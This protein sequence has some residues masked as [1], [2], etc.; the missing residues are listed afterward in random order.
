MEIGAI[1]FFVKDMEKMVTSWSKSS[2]PDVQVQYRLLNALSERG[3]AVSK[4]V[5]W[6]INP[7]GNKVLLTRFYGSPIHKV[8]DKKMKQLASILAKIHPIDMVSL[9]YTNT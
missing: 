7:D 8:N 9:T 3:V 5:G 4:P 6:G 1:T 2:K